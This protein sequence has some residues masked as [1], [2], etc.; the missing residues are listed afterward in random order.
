VLT[1]INTAFS[2]DQERKVYV[3]HKMQLQAAELFS[4]LEAGAY[5]YIC[6]AKEPMSVDVE[7]TLLAIIQQQGKKNAAQAESYLDELKE[8]G[9]YVK[10]VY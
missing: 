7:N 6:G 5:V 4:W 2:R 1:R 8:A 10:D 3:Q 9:R